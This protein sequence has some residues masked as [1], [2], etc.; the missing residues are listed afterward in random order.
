MNQCIEYLI[1]LS[2]DGYNIVTVILLLI[3]IAINKPA[4]K[5]VPVSNDN[6]SK[7][8]GNILQNPGHVDICSPPSQRFSIDKRTLNNMANKRL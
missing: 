5:E 8:V 3:S 4:A 2:V 7:G 6:V 1:V